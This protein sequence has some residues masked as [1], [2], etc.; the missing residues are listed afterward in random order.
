MARKFKSGRSPP[1]AIRPVIALRLASEPHIDVRAVTDLIVKTRLHIGAILRSYNRR[2]VVATDIRP[3]PR[4]IRKREQVQQRG[5]EGTPERREITS[6]HRGGTILVPS[7]SCRAEG[8]SRSGG[9]RI[10]EIPV[11]FRNRG[12]RPQLRSGIPNLTLK[13]QTYKE[14]QP[15]FSFPSGTATLA[16]TRQDDRAADVT[17]RVLE[18]G[19]GLLGPS[20][21]V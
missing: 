9:E 20:D 14:E 12:N 18:A 21:S 17:T 16:E 11:S 19:V 1:N 4:K 15:V 13:L 6:C 10:A 8:V 7:C 5:A 2:G 3:G